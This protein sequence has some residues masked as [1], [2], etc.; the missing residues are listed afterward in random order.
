MLTS[1]SPVNQN[2]FL[3]REVIDDIDVIYIRNNYSNKMGIIAR[4]F[5]FIKFMF[6]STL[7]AFR[8]KNVDLVYATSTPLTIGFPALILKLFKGKKYLFE[9]RDLW[10][11]VPIQMGGLKNKILIR[12]AIWF[13]KT[14]YHHA[15]HIVTLS[16]GMLEGV[17]KRGIPEEKVSIIPNMSKIDQFYSREHN[18]LIAEE[19]GINTK[20]FN[21]VYFGALG[22]S[23]GLGYI[24]DAARILKERKVADI[25]LIILGAGGQVKMLREKVAQFNLSNVK[26]IGAHPMDIVSEIVNLCNCTIVTFANIPILQTNSPNKLFDSLSAGKPIIVNSAG[27]TKK[28]VEE[29]N[30]GAYVDP[31]NPS[32][33]VDLLIRWKNCP[34]ILTELGKNA[35]RLAETEYDKSILTKK[36]VKIIE[37]YV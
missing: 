25:E 8:E 15:E 37:Q 10:P 29:Y 32:N 14:I 7:I 34:A 4:L 13:E 18:L 12:I 36:F 1:I 5:S 26:I 28:L 24:I 16:P 17:L 31:E 23:N 3:Q 9:V 11:E 30:C 6:F 2:R 27:W 21:L 20:Q 22:I 35:R 33:L 19:Y